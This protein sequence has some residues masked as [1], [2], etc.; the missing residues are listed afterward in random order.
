[1]SGVDKK[2]ACF[3]HRRCSGAPVA[4][5]GQKGI[6][7]EPPSRWRVKSGAAPATVGGESFF[8]L[9]LSFVHQSLG[10][11]RRMRTREPGDLPEHVILPP[12]GARAR[13]GL[14][15]W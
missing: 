1:M 4:L 11:R 3:F 2:G 12:C 10:R 8:R 15:L 9:P 7:C 14:P 6:R 5:I 13:G